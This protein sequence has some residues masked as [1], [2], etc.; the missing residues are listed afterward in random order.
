M[1]PSRP[2]YCTVNLDAIRYNYRRIGEI[3]KTRVMA[4]VKANGYGHGAVEVARAVEEVGC[5]WIGVAFA[6]E[7]L[8]LR[9]AGIAANILV[10]GYT[11]PAL[12]ADAIEQDFAGSL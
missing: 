11:S 8:A 12:A 10:L 6:G 9:Q 5:S 1:T 4:V 2:T 3:A 7:A